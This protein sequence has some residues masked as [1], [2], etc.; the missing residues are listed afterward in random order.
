MDPLSALSIAAA[1]VQFVQFGCSL[2]SKAYQYHGSASG[3]LPEHIECESATAR[4]VKLTEGI[5]SS[6]SKVT[7]GPEEKAIEAVCQACSEISNELLARLQKLR[8]QPGI[9]ERRWKSF[10]QA[11]KTIWLKED[12]EVMEKRLLTCQRELDSHLIAS[13]WY[14]F[15]AL[16]LP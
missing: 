5:K 3:N 13:T 12:M 7:F 15:T 1:V 6:A 11:L 14:E 10:R 16:P 9:R 8:L 4:V 2:V